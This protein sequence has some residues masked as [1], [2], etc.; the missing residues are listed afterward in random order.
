M[1]THSESQ[2]EGRA[3]VL[4]HD[5]KRNGARRPMNVFRLALPMIYAGM[6]IALGTLTGVAIAF[7]TVPAGATVAANNSTPNIS[8]T[9]ATGASSPKTG[10]E[11]PASVIRVAEQ[12]KA[13]SARVDPPGPGTT[14][15]Q[16]AA[17]ENEALPSQPAPDNKTPDAEERP[18]SS[19]E[20]AVPQPRKRVA[21]PLTVPARKV[22]AS[23]PATEPMDLDAAQLSADSDTKSP[24]FYSEGDLTVADYDAAGGTIETSDG[25]VFVVGQTVSVSSAA[26]WEDYRSSVH[27]RCGED[28]SCTLMRQGAIAP[29]ARIAQTI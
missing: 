29:N 26:S 8:N 2:P 21:H 16:G 23:E 12:T 13:S 3:L 14:A 22:L 27:Y 17:K 25:R 7:M 5:A 20:P 18:A 11:H 10:N 6:G 24:D 4:V 9:Y 19:D 28:G 15:P 1:A